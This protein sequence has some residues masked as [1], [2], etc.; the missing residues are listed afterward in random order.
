MSQKISFPWLLLAFLVLF[1]SPFDSFVF[2]P[3]R[4]RVDQEIRE[5]EKLQSDLERAEKQK[6]QLATEMD[7][8]HS[9]IEHTNN[10]NLR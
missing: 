9:A 7:E 8:H 10:L 1:N 2:V 3:L 5:K 6:T 4:E